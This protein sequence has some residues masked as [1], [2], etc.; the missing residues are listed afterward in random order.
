M[1]ISV[2]IYLNI[3]KS[4]ENLGGRGLFYFKYFMVFIIIIE[5]MMSYTMISS[6]YIGYTEKR[7]KFIMIPIISIVM[8]IIVLITLAITVFI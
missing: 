6:A 7:S 1:D 2:I 3:F 4:I 8:S 5:L